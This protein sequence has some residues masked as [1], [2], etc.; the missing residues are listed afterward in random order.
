MRIL[1][2]DDVRAAITMPEAIE[3]VRAGFKALSMEEATVPV[4]TV[5]PTPDGITLDPVQV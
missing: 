1:T 2:A 3:A 5:L 4:R